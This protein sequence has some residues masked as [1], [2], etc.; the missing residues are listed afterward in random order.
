VRLTCVATDLADLIESDAA[1]AETKT[2]PDIHLPHVLL[3]T[4][5]SH[6]KLPG[7]TD[8]IVTNVDSLVDETEVKTAHENYKP[9]YCHSG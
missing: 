8:T 7:L 4:A 3:H 6:C 2:T 5:T 1:A 9:T